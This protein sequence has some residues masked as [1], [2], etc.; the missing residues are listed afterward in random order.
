MTNLVGLLDRETLARE[1]AEGRIE[2]V[3]TAIPDLYGRLV[4][5]RITGRFFLE[6]VAD[7]GMHVAV[8]QFLV[9]L[10]LVFEEPQFGFGNEF[11]GRH[12]RGSAHFD[13]QFDLRFVEILK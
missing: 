1:I 6:E 13:R 2:T 8:A 5:K 12:H 9:G 11:F 10:S 7:H 4:G 3:I